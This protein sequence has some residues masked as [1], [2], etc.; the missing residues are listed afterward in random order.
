MNFPAL[1]RCL[2]PH[3]R[4]RSDIRNMPDCLRRIAL[5]MSD[6]VNIWQQ[7][8]LSLITKIRLYSACVM[9]VLLYTVLKR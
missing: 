4:T 8:N 1:D 3:K 6:L 9:S 2:S 7:L 5:A